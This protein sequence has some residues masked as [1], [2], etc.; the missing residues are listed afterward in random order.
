MLLANQINLSR[1]CVL[2]FQLVQ[3][4]FFK[5]VISKAQTADPGHLRQS[6]TLCSFTSSFL[7]NVTRSIQT[8]ASSISRAELQTRTTRKKTKQIENNHNQKCLSITSVRS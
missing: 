7:T 5:S 8:S 3:N 4:F 6:V 1:F 2:M